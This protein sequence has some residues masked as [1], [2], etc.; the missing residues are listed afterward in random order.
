MWP[1]A[2]GFGQCDVKHQSSGNSPAYRRSKPRF[3]ASTLK[4][5]REPEFGT[6][7]RTLLSVSP[8]RL[9]L[10]EEY[11]L[12]FATGILSIP[13]NA[14]FDRLYSAEFQDISVKTAQRV[15]EEKPACSATIWMRQYGFSSCL[16][17]CTSD[18]QDLVPMVT[19]TRADLPLSDAF[20]RL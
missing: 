6:P 20:Q 10:R 11:L 12:R 4:L 2:R 14:P 17:R 9:G 7:V 18:R 5:S 3:I 19:I 16:S 15:R 13:E 1:F 8:K